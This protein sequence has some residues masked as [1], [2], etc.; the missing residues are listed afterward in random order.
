MKGLHHSVIEIKDTENK[1]VEKILIFLKPGENS[2]TVSDAEMDASDILK[3]V[4]IR[5]N[6]KAHFSNQKSLLLLLALI[7]FSAILIY[8]IF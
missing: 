5:K 1:N 8:T 7:L 2:F 6:F 4:R 3:K